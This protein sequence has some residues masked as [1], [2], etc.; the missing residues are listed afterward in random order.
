[1]PAAETPPGAS[2]SPSARCARPGAA[3]RRPVR[4]GRDRAAH[5]RVTARTSSATATCARRAR[6][7][8]SCTRTRTACARP[9]VQR[10]GV[11]VEVTWDEAWEEVD[12]RLSA[13]DRPS[14]AGRRSR[15]TSATR[16]PTTWPPRMYLRPLL[17]AL[18]T[19]NRFSASTVDQAPKQVAAG[20]LFGTPVS[21][22]GARPRPHRL[23]A[24]ARRQPV[25]VAT[26]ASAPRR[27][28]PA[29]S[30]RCGP[31]VAAWSWSTRGGAARRRP[32]TSGCRSCPG[33]DAHLL[34]GSGPR[35]VRATAWRTPGDHVR[36]LG[37]RA[38]RAGRAVPAVHAGGGGRGVRDRGR[39]R[40]GA[41]PTSWRRRRRP[42][43]TAGSAPARRPTARRRP[44]W[45]TP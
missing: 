12:R 20:Y 9:L 29:G 8:S 16:P 24:D 11:H 34:H 13:G 14:T 10:D 43:S 19:R 27:T 31:A 22:A 28:S 21:V 5:P 36:A 25:R 4:R 39:P 17:Q 6:R 38:R 23:P 3:W 2:P 37:R 33:T 18:G 30:R 44:G 15:C 7:S 42:R 45:S 40:S 26:A 32:P 41:S 1:M 35:A